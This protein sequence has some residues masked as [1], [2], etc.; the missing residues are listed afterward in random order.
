[1]ADSE[2]VH[3]DWKLARRVVE[4]VYKGAY[5]PTGERCLEHADGMVEILKTVGKDDELFAAAYLDRTEARRLTYI[6][7]NTTRAG[8]ILEG[9]DASPEQLS[10]LFPESLRE[11]NVFL[12]PFDRSWAVT[13][14][15][16]AFYY[17]RLEPLVTDNTK[18]ALLTYTD[19]DGKE[20]YSC[21][22]RY[23]LL[24]PSEKGGARP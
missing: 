7:E 22:I 20:L 8:E 4:P 11:G 5:L 23:P 16:N 13:E 12:I 15:E 19:V 2:A 21:E 1:M 6:Q 9:W 18:G 24:R 10:A 14:K 3:A 17:L